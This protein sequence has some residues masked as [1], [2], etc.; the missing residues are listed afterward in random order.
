MP[1]TMV[2]IL[3]T[4]RDPLILVVTLTQACLDFWNMNNLLRLMY[5]PKKGQKGQKGQGVVAFG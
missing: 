4:R 1:K 3:L 5:P 2:I